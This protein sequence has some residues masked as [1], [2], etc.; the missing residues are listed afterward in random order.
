MKIITIVFYLL[1]ITSYAC[2]AHNSNRDSWQQPEKIMDTVGVKPGMVIGEVGA[3]EGYFTFKLAKRV[4]EHGKIYANDINEKVLRAID[5][6][7]KREE[8]NNIKTIL[9]KVVD[10][11]FPKKE[12][13]M[14]IMM[15]AFH[16]FTQPVALLENLKVALKPNATVVIVDRDPDKWGHD[17]HHF[18]TKEEILNTV[19]KA[20]MELLRIATFLPRDIIFIFRVKN[21]KLQA[22]D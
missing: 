11:L 6:C 17:R 19:K 16:D 21:K 14:A 1:I 13:D 5:S 2:T 10:P 18:M 3:G 4:G 22:S 12:L 20:D 15:L 9:G 8:I 7:C